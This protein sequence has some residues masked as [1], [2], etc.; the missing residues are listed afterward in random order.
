MV[1]QVREY[2]VLDLMART[3]IAV[4]VMLSAIEDL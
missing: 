3:P 4:V 1:Q 2:F